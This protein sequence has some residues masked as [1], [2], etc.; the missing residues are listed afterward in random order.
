MLKP[1]INEREQIEVAW[2]LKVISITELDFPLDIDTNGK[3]M[4]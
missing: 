2:K 1:S 4:Q 3:K